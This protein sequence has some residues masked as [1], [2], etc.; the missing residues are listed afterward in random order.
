E[1]D[2]QEHLRQQEVNAQKLRF[3]TNISHE[4]RTPLTLISG[5]LERLLDGFTGSSRVYR[6]LQVIKKNSDQLYR[7]INEL[8]DFRKLE[9]RQTTLQAA[10]GNIVDF[11]REV[12]LSFRP[13][14]REKSIRFPFRCPAEDIRLFYDRDK[15]EK[16]L[17]NL[18]FNAL[19][20]TPRGGEVTLSIREE[21]D[22]VLLSVKDTGPG[23]APADRER[24]FDRYYEGTRTNDAA[25]YRPGTGIGLAI[26]RNVVELHRGKVAVISTPETGSDFRVH[27]PRGRA[28]LEDSEIIPD[29][30]GS[31]NREH[32]R[33]PAANSVPLLPPEEV[34]PESDKQEQ[35]LVLV[36][37]D[38]PDVSAFMHEVL[39]VHYRV[40]MVENGKAGYERA[41]AGQP[42]L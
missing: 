20:F 28:H 42:E 16:V 29:F 37:E 2:Q 21:K 34:L 12:H 14:A 32:Y 17:Y 18:L 26:V 38:N 15:L 33:L 7:L 13:A 31:E 30:R 11:A 27:L 35:P 22:T 23:I 10:E 40:E 1:M 9:T 4:F 36:A 24:V 3:F 19:K 39:G 8:M 6:Q 5:S 25:V 41:I